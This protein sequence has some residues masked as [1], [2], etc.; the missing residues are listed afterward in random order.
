MYSL[1]VVFTEGFE[2]LYFNSFSTDF[3]KRSRFN[4]PYN[5]HENICYPLLATMF[6]NDAV[7]FLLEFLAAICAVAVCGPCLLA[8]ARRLILGDELLQKQGSQ[9]KWYPFCTVDS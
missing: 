5:R 7:M 4:I 3:F 1:S 6:W 9:S 2:F 8:C